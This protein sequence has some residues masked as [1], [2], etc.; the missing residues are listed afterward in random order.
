MRELPGS[1]YSHTLQPVSKAGDKFA[2]SNRVNAL[3]VACQIVP[4]I[5]LNI[6]THSNSVTFP[7]FW[8]RARRFRDGFDTGLLHIENTR[9]E[10]N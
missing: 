6:I 8:T 2:I 9:S 4:A 3:L 7:N 1:A 10:P 5:E